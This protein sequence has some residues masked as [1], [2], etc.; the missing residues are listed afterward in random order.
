MLTIMI[1]SKNGI[2]T[3]KQLTCI[4]ESVRAAVMDKYKSLREKGTLLS[5][6]QDPVWVTTDQKF[7]CSFLFNTR[8]ADLKTVCA[9]NGMDY[10]SVIDTV[11]SFVLLR[12]G[13]SGL[14]DLSNA[15]TFILNALADSGFGHD[16]SALA[17][18]ESGNGL[19]YYLDLIAISGWAI[20][21]EYIRAVIGR[22]AAVYAS[23]LE[24]R[25]E[26][27]GPCV[28]NE[29][30]SYFRFDT[31]IRDFW[32]TASD[33]EKKLYYPLYLFWTVTTILPLRVTEFCLTP[34][35]CVRKD[36]NEYKLTVRRSHLKG[37]AKWKPIY[38]YYQIDKD[39]DTYEYPIPESVYRDFRGYQE[40][41]SGLHRIA[42]TLFSVELLNRTR[43]HPQA[44]CGSRLFISTDLL[45]ILHLFYT[46]IACVRYGMKLVSEEELMSR[47]V[48]AYDGSYEMYD[49]EIMMILPKHTR[50][51]SMV[52]LVMRGCNP[53]M[54]KEFAGHKDMETSVNYYGNISNLVRCAAK[55]YYDLAKRQKN[56]CYA[57]A[58]ISDINPLQLLGDD[59]HSVPVDGGMCVSKAFAA[60]KISDCARVDGRC[61][62]CRYF[63]PDASYRPEDKGRRDLNAEMRYLAKMLKSEEIEKQIEEYTV[64]CRQLEAGIAGLAAKAW[65]ELMVQ[66][67]KEPGSQPEGS[68]DGT[69]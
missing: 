42:D 61:G 39:Y 34:Y 2:I 43:L 12:L 47:Y 59:G 51:I 37:Y 29:Y 53:I 35:E 27:P 69:D 25:K 30:R 9:E 20:P 10:A 48:D 23:R 18:Y 57:P 41:V 58:G 4:D 56:E 40:L 14:K 28:L 5:N 8:Q 62:N 60:G 7:R 31:I 11:K 13:T 33:E 68:R 66:K 63:R 52:N 1:K 45:D 3:R 36:G 49:D 22:E 50:H 24:K 54:I 19:G 26:G 38:H 16:A 44:G 6:Y 67:P 64:R 65:Q 46:D 15:V 32:K 55:Y 21:K 17:R